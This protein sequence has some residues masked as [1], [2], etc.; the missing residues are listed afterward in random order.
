V[1]NRVAQQVQQRFTDPFGERSVESHFAAPELHL[2]FF[3]RNARGD[4]RST[5]RA[6]EHGQE[7]LHAQSQH[8]LFQRAEIFPQPRRALPERS[9]RHRPRAQM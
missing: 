5:C 3:A 2:N 9:F 4:A 8:A 6:F 1:V 7:R